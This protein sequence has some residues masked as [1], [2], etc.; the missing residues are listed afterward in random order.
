VQTSTDAWQL[1]RRA[2]IEMVNGA[3]AVDSVLLASK[4]G[5][6]IAVSGKSGADSSVNFSIRTDSVPLADIGELTQSPT[7]LEGTAS[8]RTDITGTRDNPILKF[9]ADLRHGLM[10]GLRIDELHATGD[11]A[12]RSLSTAFTYMRIGIQALHGDAKLPVDLGFNT[13]GPRL[14]EAPL[15]ANIHTDSAGVAVIASLSQSVTK[16]GGAMTFDAAV[17][18]TWKHPLINGALTMHNGELSLEQLGSAHLTGVEAN[19]I[20]KGDSIGGTISAKS[21]ANKPATGELSGYV[22]IRDIDRPAYNLKLAMQNFNVIDK[23]RFAT[24]DLTGNVGLTGTSDDATLSGALTVDR[25]SISIP[26]L[27][28][29]HLISLDDPEFYRIVDTTAFEDRHL[30]PAPPASIISNLTVDNLRVEMGRDVWLKSSEANINLGGEVTIQQNGRSQRGKTAGRVQLALDGTLQTVRGTYR[31]NIAPGVSRTFQVENGDVRFF[32]DQDLNGALNINTVYTVRQFTQQGVRPDVRVR[33][34][35]G[36]TLLVPTIELSSADSSRASQADLV[37][38][39]ATGQPSNQIGVNGD[40]TS[41][42]VNVFLNSGVQFNASFCDEGIGLSSGVYDPAQGRGTNSIL[43]GAR[44]NCSRQIGE[45]TVVR[46]DYGLCQFGQIVGA[47]TGNSDPLTFADAIGLKV[48]HQLSNT[49][50]LS[51]GIEPPT[52]ALLCTSN[53][54]ARGFA[55]TPRQFGIDLFKVWRF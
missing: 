48:E 7:P 18:G 16:A 9:D 29:K 6:F 12:N 19:V 14:L 41:T 51:A 53:A 50:T 43:Y 30:L 49:F 34:H 24:L 46:L 33:V 44:L 37:S 47:S 4:S 28:T 45:K 38:Y 21:G 54:T 10:L 55:P 52:D 32:G 23:A 11:Y 36:G 26:D 8:L 2:Q 25:G 1:R 15:V 27:A 42:A 17:S 31:L 5:G 35:M 40:Y 20:F 22:S 13:V 39:L 3:V